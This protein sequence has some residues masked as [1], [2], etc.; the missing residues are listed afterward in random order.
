MLKGVTWLAPDTSA[1]APPTPPLTLL[2]LLL[3]LFL[4]LLLSCTLA[5]ST[6]PA[7][8]TALLLS[9]TA[10]GPAV[11]AVAAFLPDSDVVG[12]VLSTRIHKLRDPSG[13][14]A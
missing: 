6:L 3:L 12:D 2:L 8:P 14:I 11:L 10:T 1:A 4:L 7:G 9:A 13:M 5:M